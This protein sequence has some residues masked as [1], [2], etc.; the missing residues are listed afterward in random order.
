M[1][2]TAARR[3]HLVTAALLLPALLFLAVCFVVPMAV[4][5]KLSVTAEEGPLSAYGEI[6]GNWVYLRVFWNT[7]VV[8]VVVT[9][10]SVVLAYP[11]AHLLTRLKGWALTLAVYGVLF[12]LWI[13]VL[14]RTFSWILLL[15]KNGPV[16]RVLV[17]AGLVD[18]PVQFLF[19]NTGVLI[20]M[21]HVLLPYA[22]LPIYANMLRIDLR[23]LLASDGLA[24]SPWMTFRR[25]YLPLTMPGVGAGAVFVFLLSLGFFITP[26][27]LGGISNLTVAMLIELMVNERLVWSLAAAASFLLLAAI[28][29]LLALATR[30]VPLGAVL[31]AR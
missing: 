28:A 24:A 19:N 15:E 27:L 21:V 25:V 6:L 30:F 4:L 9:A 5:F 7:L 20:G 17:G 14:I 1:V 10:I 22:I 13:S 29:A 16:N 3:G 11:T 23:L 12:P 8:A 2:L 31:E 26:A 18:G